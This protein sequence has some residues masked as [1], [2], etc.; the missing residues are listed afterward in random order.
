MLNMQIKRQN[1]FKQILIQ[2]KRKIYYFEIY[3]C[4]HNSFG[5]KLLNESSAVVIKRVG[6]KKTSR[7]IIYI[8]ETWMYN[9]GF[10]SILLKYIL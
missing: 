6:N 8:Y 1:L 5:L 7:S 4:F 3:L 9:E 2:N 10:F